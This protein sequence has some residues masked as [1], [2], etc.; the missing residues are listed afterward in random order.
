MHKSVNLELERKANTKE[1][2][3]MT[4][5]DTLLQQAIAIFQ[6]NGIADYSEQDL[7][8]VLDVNQST[9]DEMFKNKEDLVLQAVKF[10]GEEDRK[11]QLKLTAQAENAL[12]ELLVLVQDGLENMKGLMYNE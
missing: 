12:E 9:F 5:K 7:A 6:K 2:T 10:Q 1:Q 8:K 4:F 3:D 11:R